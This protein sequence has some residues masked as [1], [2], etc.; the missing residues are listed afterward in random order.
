MS[1][2]N[3]LDFDHASMRAYFSQIGEKPFRADQVMQWIH[4]HGHQDFEHMTN[5][6]KSLR[7][8]LN[9]HVSIGLPKIVCE[10]KSQDQT[11][12]WLLEL[13][14]HQFIEMVFIPEA[15]RGTLCVSSQVGCPL[16]CSF[17]ATG[18]IGFK[19][20]LSV[21]EM[22]GQVWLAVRC[23]SKDQKKHD[24]QITN[25]VMMGMGEP[26][27]NLDNV[28]KA[29][30]I[31]MDDL[32]YGLSKYRVTLSTAGVTPAI[33]QLSSLTEASLAVSLHAPNNT[34][35]DQIMP[36]NKTYP[37]EGLLTA[38]QQFFDRDSK[39]KVSFEYILLDGIN[40]QK[41]HA[42][43]LVKILQ[44][45]PSKV[46]LI[47]YNTV[48]GIHYRCSKVETIEIFQNILLGAGIRTIVRKKRGSDIEAACGQLAGK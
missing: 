28:V 26:L 2:I 6:S 27:L 7:R 35:R 33:E 41:E 8:Y 21:S 44:N 34:L 20:N 24:H 14:D 38:C 30:A 25:I 3:L 45:I 15:D 40:D 13:S 10:K 37:L 19:R 31:M 5:F 47:P 46:N 18:Q 48:P 12:K 22:I 32:A 42:Y 39:R 43:Q 17:C 4:Q 16:N 23:L 1:I 9:E 36:I 11:I 29:M